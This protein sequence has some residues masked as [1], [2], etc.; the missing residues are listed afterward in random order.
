M[1]TEELNP[2]GSNMKSLCYQPPFYAGGNQVP[3]YLGVKGNYDRQSLPAKSVSVLT[4]TE[5]VISESGDKK[6]TKP[7]LID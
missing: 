7:I 1:N 4:P 2:K 5:K 3:F 6:F